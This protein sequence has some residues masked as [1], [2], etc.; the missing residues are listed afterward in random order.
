MKEGEN[1]NI[2]QVWPYLLGHYKWNF[3]LSECSEVDKQTTLSYENKVSH[4]MAMEAI[5]RQ[6]D[7]EITAASIANAK[8]IG[9]Y[10]NQWLSLN[11]KESNF[12]TKNLYI[13]EHGADFC[14]WI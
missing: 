9:K 5:V 4:W 7:R 10:F 8:I 3:T 6:R 13:S 2:F 1:E 11:N 12:K 14:T